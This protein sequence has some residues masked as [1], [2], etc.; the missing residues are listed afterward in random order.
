MKRVC[1]LLCCILLLNLCA[2]SRHKEELLQP[3]NFYY[4]TKEISYNTQEGVICAEVRESIHFQDDLASL[5]H[6]YL[7]GPINPELQTFIPSDVSLISCSVNHN[8][9]VITLSDAFSKLSGIKLSTT[10]ACMLMTINHYT[11][12]DTLCVRV[13]NALLDDKDEIIVTLDDVLLMDGIEITQ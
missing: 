13:E 1:I 12:I 9:A 2:C 11:D 3:T 6:A 4:C 8:T 10:C 7:L 5:L